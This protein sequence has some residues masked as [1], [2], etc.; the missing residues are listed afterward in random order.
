MSHQLRIKAN[1]TAELWLYEVN[2]VHP[3]S[4]AMLHNLNKMKVGRTIDNL[5]QFLQGLFI[6]TLKF[7]DFSSVDMCTLNMFRV[8]ISAAALLTTEGKDHMLCPI[9]ASIMCL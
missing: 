7:R 8:L 1:S 4:K 6:F 9:L 3:R 2:R 5:S